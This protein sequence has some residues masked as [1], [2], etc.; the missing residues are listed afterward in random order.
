M[1]TGSEAQGGGMKAMDVAPRM[2]LLFNGLA[3]GS[4]TLATLLPIVSV[5][6]WL[7]VDPGEARQAVGLP[8]ELLP[9]IAMG[10]RLAAA[11]VALVICLPM[12]WG[13]A[14]LRTCLANF[15]A[16]R[17]FTVEGIAGLRDFALGGMLAALAQLLGHTAMGLVLT[18][19]AAP[20]HRQL[21]LRI[22]SDMLLLAMFAGTV[23]ALAWAMEK[24]AAL[25]EENSQFI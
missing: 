10:Q 1:V 6:Y 21:V 11:V 16:G 3:I 14:R 7:L 5:T 19:T 18:W 8:P 15:A 23:A 24:A 22:D 2:G 13:F 9:D 4:V 25:A 20:G 17:P 12:A